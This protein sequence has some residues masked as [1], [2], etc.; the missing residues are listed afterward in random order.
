MI[1]IPWKLFYRLLLFYHPQ[2]VARQTSAL[3]NVAKILATATESNTPIDNAAAEVVLNIY[4]SL[5]AAKSFEITTPPEAAKPHG[6][7]APELK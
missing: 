6:A 4:R 1:I 5:E 2:S 3:H 7:T